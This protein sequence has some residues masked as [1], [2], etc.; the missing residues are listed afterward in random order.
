MIATVTWVGHDISPARNMPEKFAALF[1]QIGLP[2][3]L[4]RHEDGAF[5]KRSSIRRNLK[6][7]ALRF[8]GDGKHFDKGAFRK[9][10]RRD[11]HVTYLPEIFSNTKGPVV[12]AFSNF[13][14]AFS[15]KTFYAF[16]EWPRRFSRIFDDDDDE[17]YRP[18]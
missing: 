11:I 4:I 18:H 14:D 9:R 17:A 1:L 3:S 5:R 15:P 6:T 16:L 10:W 13:S 12:V 2:S 7:Q 8:C